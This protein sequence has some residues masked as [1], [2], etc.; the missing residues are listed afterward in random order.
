MPPAGPPVVVYDLV[1]RLASAERWSSRE[2]VLF[3]TPDAEPHLADGFYQENKPVGGAGFV[4]SRQRK[5]VVVHVAGSSPT[6]PPSWRWRRLPGVH[7]QSV[8]SLRTARRWSA[9]SLNESRHRYRLSLPA[10]GATS[11]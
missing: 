11:W 3:G 10:A 4:W 1:A 6:A 9:A 5:R 8:R 7:N 2:V